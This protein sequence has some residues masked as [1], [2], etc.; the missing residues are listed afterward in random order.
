M[1]E[2]IRRSIL[3]A[4][5]SMQKIV[6]T[7]DADQAGEVLVELKSVNPDAAETVAI[8]LEGKYRGALAGA[9][10]DDIRE[11]LGILE[12]IEDFVRL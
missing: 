4:Y 6:L 2:A 12:E 1:N 3:S 10:R 9:R 7:L 11:D 5:E 8:I